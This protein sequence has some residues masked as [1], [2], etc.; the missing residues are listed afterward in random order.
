MSGRET[1]EAFVGFNSAW[2][3]NAKR[4]GAIC[5]VTMAGSHVVKYDAPQSMGFK[6]AAEFI[7]KVANESDYTLIAIDQPTI[8]RNPSG[9]RPVER[10]AGSVINAIAGGVQCT[11]RGKVEMFGDV[12]PIWWL[13]DGLQ[14]R[15]N[16]YR[17]SRGT[18]RDIL[19]RGV[20]GVGADS[21]CSDHLGSSKSSKIQPSKQ[22]VHH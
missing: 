7:R 14:A 20:P 22:A 18:V 12:A 17:G 3:D 21:P 9:C 15:Q 5:S 8:V 11:N 1:V 6:E 16:P 19:D 4:P 10:V 13:L 2:T